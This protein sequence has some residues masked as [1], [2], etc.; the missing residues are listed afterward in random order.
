M[1]IKG[2]LFDT[3]EQC[4]NAIDLIN[5]SLGLPDEHHTSH[6][7]ASQNDGKWFIVED[8]FTIPILGEGIEF[9]FI[10]P[11]RTE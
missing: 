8:N 3:E 5:Q 7:Q 10:R 4:Q 2:Y 11:P 1:T 6:S 9:E